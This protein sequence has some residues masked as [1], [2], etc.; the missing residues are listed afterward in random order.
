M[1]R[2]VRAGRDLGWADGSGRVE[3]SGGQT[4]QDQLLVYIDRTV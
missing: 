1:G 4:G 2:G 3:M